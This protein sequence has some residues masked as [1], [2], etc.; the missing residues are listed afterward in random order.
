MSICHF[1][2]AQDTD[3]P[4]P[5]KFT[6]CT[7]AIK[8]GADGI[9]FQS[10]ARL[11]E[12]TS[13]TDRTIRRHLAEL[14]HLGYLIPTGKFTGKTGQIPMYKIIS[15]PDTSVRLSTQPKADTSDQRPPLRRTPVT[16]K[17][18]TSD[19]RKVSKVSKEQSKRSPAKKKKAKSKRFIK[20]TAEQIQEYCDER[21]NGLDGEQIFDSYE[22]K[23]WMINR[24]PVKDWKACVRTWEKHRN[25]YPTNKGKQNEESIRLSNS[26][27]RTSQLNEFYDRLERGG[28]KGSG[29]NI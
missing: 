21:Q 29:K 19:T 22:S 15:N 16:K 24:N 1:E 8:T 18:D 2:S 5:I 25:N 13:Q 17:A 12:K 4:A 27:K 14:R 23:G 10:N 11:A 6:L 26:G 9:C 28:A 20:P 3:L 7:L